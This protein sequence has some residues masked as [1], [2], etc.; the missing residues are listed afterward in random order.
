MSTSFS[1]S[2]VLAERGV[3]ARVRIPV[4]DLAARRANIPELRLNTEAIIVTLTVLINERMDTLSLSLSLRQI[5]MATAVQLLCSIRSPR[6]SSSHI[7]HATLIAR[8]PRRR[9]R[10]PVARAGCGRCFARERQTCDIVCS[11]DANVTHARRCLF[12][13]FAVQY[14]T[15]SVSEFWTSYAR[16]HSP[17]PQYRVLYAAFSALLL[18]VE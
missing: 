6:P 5:L 15:L 16:Q 13:L 8:S 17:L 4:A 11:S 10:R 1:G 9:H 18:L 14:S 12:E 2:G 7:S 3:T